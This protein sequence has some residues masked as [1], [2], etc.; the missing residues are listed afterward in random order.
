MTIE[1]IKTLLPVINKKQYFHK[2]IGIGI[3]NTFKQQYWYWHRQYF[4]TK[5][6][7][8]L[9]TIVITSIVNILAFCNV[10]F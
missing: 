9:W 7:L 8:L 1:K 4:I 6:L 2:S 10:C 3:D 5:E